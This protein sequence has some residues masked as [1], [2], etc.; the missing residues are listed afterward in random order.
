MVTKLDKT[1]RKSTAA[2]ISRAFLDDPF[3]VAALADRHRFVAQSIIFGTLMRQ[4]ARHGQVELAYGGRAAAMWLPPG[5]WQF[6]VVE[7]IRSG[8]WRLPP[9]LGPRGSARLI[10]MDDWMVRLHAKVMGDRP[11]VYLHVLAVD[12]PLQ[13]Q[14]IGTN[15]LTEG[16][17]RVDRLGVPCFLETHKPEN[18]GFY[19]RSGFE[20]VR[21]DHDYGVTNHAMV[22]MPRPPR[23][24]RVGNRVRAAQGS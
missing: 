8:M 22:R 18:V 17:K 16:L 23:A 11:H 9:I 19:V 7:M 13:H 12:P 15:L 5:R 4:I 1:L 24:E 21:E 10:Q 6:G 2:A 14:G 3:M 20:L